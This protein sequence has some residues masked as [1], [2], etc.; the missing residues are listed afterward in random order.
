MNWIRIWIAQIQAQLSALTA[1]QKM[2]IG[3]LVALVPGLL[4]LVVQYAAS[5]EMVAVL[6]Q[7]MDS[8][9][10]VQITSYLDGRGIPYRLVGDR[11]HVPAERS[12]DVLTSLQMQQ[13]LP[14]DTSRGFDAIITAQTW[15]QSSTQ[16]Q[17]MYNV[18]KQNV[19]SSVL[20]AYP[21]VRDA[22]VIISMPQQTGF[23]ATHQRPTAS[24]NIV[25]VGAALDQ[26]KVDAVAGLVSGAV[27]EMRPEDVTVIDAV[28]GRQWK[29]RGEGEA[30]P[31]DYLETLHAQ[32]RYYREKI[33]SALSYI[34]NV[35]VAV[36]VEVDLTRRQTHTTSYDRAKSVELIT[37]ESNR[38]TNTSNATTAAEPG[39]R[40]NTGADLTSRGGNSTSSTTEESENSFEPFA[41][42]VDEVATQA[43]GAPVRINATVNIPRSFFVALFRQGKPPETPEPTDDVLQPIIQEH[44]ARIRKQI[45]PLVMTKTASQVVVDVF[46]D[47]GAPG[48]TVPGTPVGAGA[49][50]LLAGGDIKPITLGGLA[51]VSVAM[52]FM[53]VRSAARRPPTPSLRELAGVPPPLPAEESEFIG[54]AGESEATLPGMEVDEDA[55]RHRQLSEQLSQMVKANP[56]EV[57]SVINRWIRKRD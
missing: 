11:V 43:G 19:L 18:A 41:G 40:A 8:A 12:L 3:V 13:L 24:V 9:Q 36:N 4:W 33:S 28:A 44:L 57:A 47:S 20:R 6:D 2:L 56:E 38:S 54:E 45:E 15:W 32:E 31:T 5:P 52:M 10:R 48:F 29:V 21:W 1:S 37:S 46:P 55:I 26:K 27:A 17:Q 39:V 50:A 53:M 7:P 22:T 23:G 34:Q 51:L 14:E 49:S 35:I 30:L 25:T 42:K 16:N